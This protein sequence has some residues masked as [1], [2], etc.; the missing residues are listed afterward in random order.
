[1]SNVAFKMKRRAVLVK[2][3]ADYGTDA[4]PTGAA[5]A[6]LCRSVAVTPLA[7][8]DI[9][10]DLIRTY[11]GNSQQIAGEKH[12][13]LDLEVELAGSGAAGTAPAWGPLLRACGFAE[14]VNAS[15]DV[16]Y[17][18]ISDEEEAVTVYVHRDGILHK[19]TGGR[20]SVSFGLSTD[21]I[22]VMKFKYMG[23]FAPISQA[24]LPTTD[25]TDWQEPLPVSS[26][27]TTGFTLHGAALSFSQ[28]DIDMA[29]ET[30]KH[31]VVGPASSIQIV[32]RKPSG[33][34]V[35]Q[36]PPL[37]TLDLYEKA[38]DASL[39]ALALVHGTTPGNIVEV[40]APKVGSG[41]PTEQELNG[42]QML[43]L[44]LTINP[45]AGNDELV[46]TVK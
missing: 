43:S 26:A 6:I 13:E 28:L 27:N 4:A 39:G 19:F 42:V 29:V 17:N 21:Q 46:I 14:T 33:T 11:Y 31:K 25:Y 2:I 23:L 24:A 38:R 10:R 37:A 20:G 12:V 8:E 18:P 5:N 1:M 35:V 40:S 44:P 36:E 32:D 9:S 3:E 41:S 16:V 7:G 15:T 30:V 22:P 34:V 45:D